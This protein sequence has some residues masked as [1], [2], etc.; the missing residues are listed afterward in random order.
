MT[1]VS[2]S[3]MRVHSLEAWREMIVQTMLSECSAVNTQQFERDSAAIVVPDKSIVGVG[4]K[5]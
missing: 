2:S 3:L 4:E 5:D 1:S